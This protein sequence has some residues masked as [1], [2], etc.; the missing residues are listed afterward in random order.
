MKTVDTRKAWLDEIQMVTNHALNK[1]LDKE[2]DGRYVTPIEQ[3]LAKVCGAYLYL[4]NLA[5]ENN[6]LRADDPDNPFKNET[7]H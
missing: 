4:F 1:I 5:E 3:Q 6:L 7:L 2:A